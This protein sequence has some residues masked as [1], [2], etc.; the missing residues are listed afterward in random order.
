MIVYHFYIITKITHSELTVI[1]VSFYNQTKL[2]SEINNSEP[3]NL[4]IYTAISIHASLTQKG[5]KKV[6]L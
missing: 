1:L 6:T 3:T 2:I 5:G 4:I